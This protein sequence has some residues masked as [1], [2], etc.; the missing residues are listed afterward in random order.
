MLRVVTFI[1]IIIVIVY[2]TRAIVSP[3]PWRHKTACSSLVV[4]H[5]QLGLG[6]L[7]RGY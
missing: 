7:L 5:C 6:H 1:A 3:V 4:F 2:P